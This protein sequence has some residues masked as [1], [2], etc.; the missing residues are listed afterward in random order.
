[1]LRRLLISWAGIALAFAV[2]TWIL[3]GVE[4]SGGFFAYLWVSL[5]FGFVNA[6]LGTL[7]RILT[8][9]FIVLTLGLFAIVVN[10]VVLEITDAI[11]SHLTID[12]FF[13]SAIWAAIILAVSAVVIDA[14]LSAGSTRLPQPDRVAGR[15]SG[16]GVWDTSGR[17]STSTGKATRPESVRGS[18]GSSCRSRRPGDRSRRSPSPS[19]WCAGRGGVRLVN[20]AAFR[21]SVTRRGSRS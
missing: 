8:L 13:W 10:A 5:V 17:M 11:T 1:M 9:P 4:V 3:S 12:S 7:L 18:S 14:I 19:E 2:T 15:E 6:I 20:P 21:A 16:G